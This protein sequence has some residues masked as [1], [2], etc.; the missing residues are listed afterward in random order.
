MCEQCPLFDQV[1]TIKNFMTGDETSEDKKNLGKASEAELEAEPIPPMD[2]QDVSDAP[3]DTD[4]KDELE[5][6]P[7]KTGR[8]VFGG[9]W[10]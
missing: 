6:E 5:V 8:L 2:L 7:V 9:I 1:E 3:L 4:S 10:K